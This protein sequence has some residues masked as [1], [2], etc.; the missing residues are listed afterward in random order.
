MERL[1]T[2]TDVDEN[3][4]E[5]RLKP[6]R[7]QLVVIDSRPELEAGELRR[8]ASAVFTEY[9]GR[10]LAALLRT[11]QARLR[12][13]GG[14][15]GAARAAAIADALAAVTAAAAAI[16]VPVPEPVMVELDADGDL[17]ALTAARI[18][19]APAPIG[20]RPGGE[21]PPRVFTGLTP[22]PPLKPRRGKRACESSSLRWA[23]AP[24]R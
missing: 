17:D 9:V 2:F 20:P 3:R 8:F 23:G 4:L 14:R 1:L 19:A 12:D 22:Y 5:L 16:A 11:A 24:V 7:I 21:P 10:E 18:D 6:D 13:A 15:R